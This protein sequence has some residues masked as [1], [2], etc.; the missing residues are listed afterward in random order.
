MIPKWY[1]FGCALGVSKTDMDIIKEGDDQLRG[2]HDIYAG[3][4]EE[5]S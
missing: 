2:L 3:G 5:H 4:V 1:Q